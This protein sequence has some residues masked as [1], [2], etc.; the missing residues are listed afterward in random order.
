M[1]DVFIVGRDG[2]LVTNDPQRNYLDTT[3]EDEWFFKMNNYKTVGAH[4][5]LRLAI[6][7][8]LRPIIAKWL[9][10]N[11]TSP[12]FLIVPTTMGPPGSPPPRQ[13][14]RTYLSRYIAKSMTGDAKS[15]VGSRL[16]RKHYVTT[17]FGADLAERIDVASRMGH[18][19]AVAMQHYSKK[20]PRQAPPTTS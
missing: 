15:K 3:A 6:P 17:K 2:I 9:E 1:A 12:H 19:V 11:D 4:G 16:M 20:R 14:T 18:S 13:M 5:P 8:S 10:I 7:A